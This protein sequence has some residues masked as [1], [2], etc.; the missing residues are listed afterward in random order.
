MKKQIK[1]LEKL[2]PEQWNESENTPFGTPHYKNRP[3]FALY[4]HGSE[5]QR[6]GMI[7]IPE[8]KERIFYK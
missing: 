5:F 4:A 2:T 1:I 3:P 7:Y 6:M 8:T